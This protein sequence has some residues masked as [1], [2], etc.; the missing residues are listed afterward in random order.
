MPERGAAGAGYQRHG[1]AQR[2]KKA[3]KK[4]RPRAVAA[5]KQLAASE[6]LG[7]EP[8]DTIQMAPIAPRLALIHIN[9]KCPGL[10]DASAPNSSSPE[11][12]GISSEMT[13]QDLANVSRKTI[14]KTNE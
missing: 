11:V 4:E 8:A 13:A 5:Q 9:R 14:S 10:A 12:P 2:R 6:A 7:I 1:G 3:A